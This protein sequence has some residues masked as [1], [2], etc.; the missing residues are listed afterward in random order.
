[1]P[2]STPSSALLPSKGSRRRALTVLVALA[3]LTAACTDDKS[4]AV[5]ATASTPAA[6]GPVQGGVLRFSASINPTGLDP[7]RGTS[8]SDHQFLY[9]VFDTLIEMDPST[10]EARPSLAESWT[11]TPQALTLKLRK[12]IRFHDDTPFDAKAVAANFD[13]MRNSK[14]SNVKADVAAIGGVEIVDDSTVKLVLKRPDS[15][16]PLKLAD[17]AGMM[18]S[19]AAVEKFGDDFLR[20]P[21]GTG[22]FRFVEWKSN[23]VVAYER[24]KSYWQSGLPY[25][26]GI[27]MQIHENRDTGLTA[28]EA[29]EIDII[30]NFPAR[31]IDRLKSL[32]GVTVLVN[33]SLRAP[34]VW[35]NTAIAPFDN[36]LVRRA[37]NHAI[38]RKAINDVIQLGNGEPSWTLVP[39]AHWAYPK[40][41]VPTY[42]YNPDKARQ[43]LAE[44]GHAKG[45]SAV[46]GTAAADEDVRRAE[47]IQQY[48][49]AVGVNLTIQTG[50][51][52]EISS[53]YFVKKQF[54]MLS[55]AWTG[56]PDPGLSY[57]LMFRKESYFN[58][59]KVDYP[60]LDAAMSKMAAAASQQ[61]QAAAISDVAAIVAKEAPYIPVF[62]QIDDAAYHANVRG[63][64]PNLLGKPKF[65]GVNLARD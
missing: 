60:G 40:A 55:S 15:G 11:L 18:V 56:R 46:M 62:F 64:Q 34:H 44:A 39:S 27:R 47:L 54:P 36:P 25:L 65:L 43:L 37:L 24:N 10:G 2:S 63:Y 32:K 52:A 13:R 12:G 6:T 23:D 35:M 51:L 31:A 5:P 59:G 33:S 50:P 41:I 53:L 3:G 16:L 61:E 38:D 1:M 21:V 7:H 45:F 58:V 4:K 29:G 48:L 28:F 57:E 22:A 49:K 14:V 9:P 30:Q 17:R 26:D 20:N 42:D 8:G 19:P